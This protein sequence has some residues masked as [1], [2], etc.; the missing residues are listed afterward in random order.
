[1]ARTRAHRRG[2]PQAARGNSMIEREMRASLARLEGENRA[3]HEQL[4]LVLSSKGRRLMLM[5]GHPVWTLRRAMS[6]LLG[7]K[8]LAATRDLWKEFRAHRISLSSIAPSPDG[9]GSLTA[10]TA[11][12][13]SPELGISGEVHE[14]LLCQGS[15]LFTFR[16]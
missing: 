6:W 1:M 7:R 12:Q 13:W 14:G 15:S 16:T 8:P 9:N 11:M 2:R 10:P 4:D 3:V 5:A